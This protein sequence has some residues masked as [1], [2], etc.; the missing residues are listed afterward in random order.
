MFSTIGRYP[1][2]DIRLETTDPVPQ[3][4]SREWRGP[5]WRAKDAI[6]RARHAYVPS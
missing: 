2:F 3:W 5:E 6:Q 1:R 4:V